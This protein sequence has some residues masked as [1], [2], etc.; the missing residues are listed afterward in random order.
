MPFRTTS[1]LSERQFNTLKIIAVSD[2]HGDLPNIE[3]CDLLLIPGDICPIYS[4][5]SRL[6]EH[7][8]HAQ[9][10][11]VREKFI[12]W[13]EEQPAKRVYWIGGNHDFGVELAGAYRA[14]EEV[15]PKWVK[16]LRD[17]AVEWDKHTIY[18]SPWCPNLFHWAFYAR[19]EKWLEIAKNIPTDID[20]LMLHSP[21][22]DLMTIELC[23]HHLNWASPAPLYNEIVGRIKPKLVLCGHLH[24]GYGTKVIDG[25]TFANVALKDDDY[26]ASHEPMTFYIDKRGVTIA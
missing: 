10:N 8:P 15:S 23:D 3:P 22:R 11:W 1:L 14:F 17:E 18:G 9:L 16:M 13:A 2:L 12:P 19:D 24:E 25:I 21:P 6:R 7:D 5:N 20:I 26:K 4:K